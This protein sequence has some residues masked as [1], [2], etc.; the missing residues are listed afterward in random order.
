MAHGLVLSLIPEQ[1]AELEID[2]VFLGASELQLARG[3]ALGTLRGV[4][5]DEDGLAQARG[6]LL[7]AARVGEDEVDRARLPLVNERAHLDGCWAGVKDE[8]HFFTSHYS[9]L[10]IAFAS[11]NL[12]MS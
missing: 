6:L 7:D 2:D 1:S 10:S 11:W 12:R 4:A 5:H 8:H 9:P 3:N